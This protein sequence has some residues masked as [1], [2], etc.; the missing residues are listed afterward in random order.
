MPLPN[1][2]IQAIS[3]VRAFV[4]KQISYLSVSE[5][6]EFCGEM[7]ADFEGRLDALDEADEEAIGDDYTV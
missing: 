4:E 6:R 5:Y 1:N 2:V 7:V 3:T